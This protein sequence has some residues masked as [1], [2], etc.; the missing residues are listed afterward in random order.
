MPDPMLCTSDTA[1]VCLH[2]S[3]HIFA[4]Y[5]DGG[6]V[7]FA[8]LI[9]DPMSKARA[10]VRAQFDLSARQLIA[11]GGFAVEYLLYQSGRIADSNGL[12]ITERSFIDASIDNARRD[13]LSFF[14]GDFAE[15]DG[16]WPKEMDT[17]FMNYAIDKLVPRMRQHFQKIEA[18]ASAL[19][20]KSKLG[21]DEIEAII[22]FGA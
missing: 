5:L 2:E 7:E 3:G 18:L 19:E 10:K 13:K 20:E 17:E 8:E 22:G 12:P 9:E 21:R 6:H 1:Y 4:T 14:D 11:C 15:T 16:C